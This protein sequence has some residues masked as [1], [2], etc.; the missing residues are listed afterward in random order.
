[1]VGFVD[2]QQVFGV[3]A[4]PHFSASVAPAHG[5]R[6]QDDCAAGHVGRILAGSPV[7]VGDGGH[8]GVGQHPPGLLGQFLAVGEPDGLA[9]VVQPVGQQR[10]GDDGLAATG[11]QLEHQ[12]RV[13]VS[14]QRILRL[15]EEGLLVRTELERHQL[16]I[17]FRSITRPGSSGVVSVSIRP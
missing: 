15:F 11:G 16:K 3:V 10:A 14:G 9:S 1:M 13:G 12:A 6:H 17:S 7:D 5:L 4:V 2:Y 8:A